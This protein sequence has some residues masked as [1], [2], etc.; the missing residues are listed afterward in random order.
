VK[1]H[2]IA[3][4]VSA[5]APSAYTCHSQKIEKEK[6]MLIKLI[7]L[8]MLTSLLLSSPAMWIYGQEINQEINAE[9]KSAL[10]KE[11]FALSS[12]AFAADTS[13]PTG[14]LLETLWKSYSQDPTFKR[15]N[16]KQ[17]EAL[18]KQID[19][20]SIRI[21]KRFEDLLE[22]KLTEIYYLV[23]DKAFDENELKQLV[24]FSKSPLGKKFRE[25]K[26]GNSAPLTQ[27]ES[28]GMLEFLK[29]P[30][31][32]KSMAVGAQLLNVLIKRGGELTLA[33]TREIADEEMKLFLEK[34]R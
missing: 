15:L 26:P 9:R 6:S 14:K 18:K 27:T 34:K 10:I 3:A 8:A 32:K 1:Q 4:P 29:S 7:R 28:E 12:S 16:A 30:V 17:R 5:P 33:T 25:Y 11:L 22:Q 2:N 21:E 20:S 31:G 23:Y 13:L 24:D 19:Q